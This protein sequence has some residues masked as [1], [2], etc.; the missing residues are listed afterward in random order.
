MPINP[1]C[2]WHNTCTTEIAQCLEKKKFPQTR[3]LSFPRGL[4]TKSTEARRTKSYR[5]NKEME[6]I[7]KRRGGQ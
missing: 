1:I 6:L 5:M 3:K 7:L 2:H 4:L